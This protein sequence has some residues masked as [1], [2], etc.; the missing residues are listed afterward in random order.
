MEIGLISPKGKFWG[1]NEYFGEYWHDDLN[2]ISYR[3]YW[4]GFSSGL[5]AESAWENYTCY[6]VNLAPI[7]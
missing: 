6:D 1:G 4:G 7:K 3:N 2:S 5:L